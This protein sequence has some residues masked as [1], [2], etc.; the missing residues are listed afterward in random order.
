[1]PSAT[2]VTEETG[3]PAS[4]DKSQGRDDAEIENGEVCVLHVSCVS[5]I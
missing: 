1:M 2:A 4:E 3:A 5:F